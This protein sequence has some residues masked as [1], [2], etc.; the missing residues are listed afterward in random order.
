MTET[1]L[2]P[3]IIILVIASVVVLID[4]DKE[5]VAV[6]AA[7]LVAKV[8]S[9]DVYL[10]VVVILEWVVVLEIV[11]DVVVILALAALVEDLVALVEGLVASLV[12]AALLEGLVALHSYLLPHHFSVVSL[13]F[14]T[15]M[16]GGLVAQVTDQDMDQVTARDRATAAA[17]VIAPIQTL[18]AK[19]LAT[20]ILAVKILAV[21]ILAVQI[22]ILVDIVELTIRL[23]TTKINSNSYFSYCKLF[24]NI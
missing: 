13:P 20:Q 14:I 1:V 3:A 16:T 18:A 21:Q 15:I 22:L 5:I 11:M 10:L 9:E 17:L 12:L 23:P 2:V 4:V 24:K 8:D 6:D 7:K 19:I